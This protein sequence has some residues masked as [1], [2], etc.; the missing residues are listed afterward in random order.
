MSDKDGLCCDNC[1]VEAEETDK[2][3]WNCG[4]KTFVYEPGNVKPPTPTNQEDI[5]EILL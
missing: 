5:E 4:H 2:E 3:C 1:H